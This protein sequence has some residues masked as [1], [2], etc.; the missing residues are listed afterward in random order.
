MKHIHVFWRN[1]VKQGS[2]SSPGSSLRHCAHGRIRPPYRDTCINPA[3]IHGYDRWAR[4]LLQFGQGREDA[5]RQ[6]CQ[7]V[8]T[9]NQLPTHTSSR[10]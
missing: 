9:Q 1:I 4:H 7:V 8:V 5:F 6:C 10:W 3:Y 2:A